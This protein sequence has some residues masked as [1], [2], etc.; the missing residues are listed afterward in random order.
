MQSNDHENSTFTKLDGVTTIALSMTG[1]ARESAC[2][3][4]CVVRGFGHLQYMR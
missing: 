3:C 4:V 1:V 2:V